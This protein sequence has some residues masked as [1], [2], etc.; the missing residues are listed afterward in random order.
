MNKFK[1]DITVIVPCY[2]VENYLEKCLYSLV[3]QSFNSLEVIMVEDCSTDGTKKIV[4]RYEKKYEN[5]HAIYNQKNGGLGNARNVGIAAAKSE[6]IGFLD[7]DDW[8]PENFLEE[9]YETLVSNDAD[10][11]MCDVY[12]RYDDTSR[13]RRIL[14]YNGKP[15]KRGLINTGL[16]AT[17]SAKLFKAKL[18]N[19]FQYPVGIVNEDIP[20][21][22]AMLIKYKVAYTD[23]THF[24]YYQRHGSIQNGQVTKKRLDVFIALSLLRKNVGGK[25]DKKLWDA[26]VWQQVFAVYLYVFPR[27]KGVFARK[28][29]IKDFYNACKEHGIKISPRNPGFIKYL[30]DNKIDNIYGQRVVKSLNNRRFFIASVLMGLYALIQNHISFVRL[31]VWLLRQMKHTFFHPVDSIRRL[32]SRLKTFSRRK[33]VIKKA[34]TMD[35]LIDAAIRQSKKHSDDPVSVIIPNYN[36][37]RYMLQRV[38]SILYQKEKI[39]EI[40]LLDDN[41]TDGSVAL[42]RQIKKAIGRHVTVRLINNKVNRG[43]FS[44]WELGFNMAKHWLVW[45]AEADDY[46]SKLFLSAALKPMK[47]NNNVVISYVNTGYINEKGL[48]IGDVRNDIDYQKTG[49]WNSSYVNNGLE[50]AR[51]YSYANNTIANVSSV[52]FRKRD[53]INYEELFADCRQY[54]Q[55]GDWLMYVNYMLYG[56]VAYT[57]RVLNYYRV[58]G[59]NVS[60]NTK[61]HDHINEILE[62]HRKLT[63][64]LALSPAHKRKMA[65]RIQTLK[66]AWSA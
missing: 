14:A 28:G 13:D 30:K 40:I 15:D 52:V 42:A 16:A 47:V 39:G 57:D 1:K 43:T 46:S 66:K 48:L 26:I 29:L 10:I 17:S 34:V 18:F 24:S 8:L 58:H 2:N 59:A 22:L 21:T 53:D 55:A 44:Q 64:K 61:A 11:S 3:R 50:E 9:M 6:F 25:I 32:S 54:R 19:D 27:A 7:S 12:L 35:N 65:K 31:A 51:Q 37:E 20:V 56:D 36:Y 63:E 45:I 5:F 49:H 4:R 60:S 23:K 41:S 38:Y 33:V 62:I